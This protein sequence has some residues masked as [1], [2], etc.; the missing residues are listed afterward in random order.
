MKLARQDDGGTM[1]AAMMG[2]MFPVQMA[3]DLGG[4]RVRHGNRNLAGD[5]VFDHAAG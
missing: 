4:T 2:I 5:A 1:I 3:F